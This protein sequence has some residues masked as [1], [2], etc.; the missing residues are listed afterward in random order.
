MI[1]HFLKNI[2]LVPYSTPFWLLVF[3]F[4]LCVLLGGCVF[5]YGRQRARLRDGLE[6]ARVHIAKIEALNKTLDED[7]KV[8]RGHLEDQRGLTRDLEREA[9]AL[10]TQ[11]SERQRSLSELKTRM[12][13]DFKASASQMLD[14]VQKSFLERASQTFAHYNEKADSNADIRRK[15]IDETVRPLK[16]TLS[17]YEKSLADMRAEQQKAQGAITAQIGDLAQASNQVRLEANKLSTALRAGPKTRGRWGEEQLRNVVE[18]AGMSAHVDF[19]EQ[20]THYDEDAKRK[21]PDM[22][23]RLPGGR[24][25]AIDSKVSLNAYLDALE[26]DNDEQR[27]AHLLRHANDI[28]NHVKTLSSRDYASSLG[29]DYVDSL[30][31]VIMFVPGESYFAAA[32]DQR[33]HLFQEA[34][35]KKVLIATPTT[36]V[37]ILKSTAYGWR[38]EKATQNARIVAGLAKDLYSS[39]R[40]MGTNLSG[41]GKALEG[42][43]KKYNTTI[44]G[45]EGRVMPRARKFS[46]YELPEIDE[47]LDLLSPIEETPK[48]VRGDRDLLLDH[49]DLDLQG[50]DR[51][52]KDPQSEE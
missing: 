33:P 9:T 37:A 48:E 52:S 50:L 19:T 34:F 29:R 14:D 26:A 47:P 51:Q 20:A 42:S 2:E 15:E 1:E 17:R 25:I 6:R 8:T 27:T 35:D 43:V 39:L 18:L 46:E 23:V 21:Q 41:L 3:L 31:F 4:L 12:D 13:S 28:W 24:I 44:S 36:L 10:S 5:N 32:M 11:L 7:L 30:D 16:E 40:T 22:V 49:Q 45:I 38:Q